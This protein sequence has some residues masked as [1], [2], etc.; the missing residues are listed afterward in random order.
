VPISIDT[1]KASTARLALVAGAKIIN[2]VWGLQR[3][4]DIARVAAEAGAPVIAMHN[5][6]FLDGSLDVLDDMRAYF[7]RSLAIAQ[8][9]GIPKE[10]VVL[11]PGIGFGKTFDQNLDALR[12]LAELRAL[13]QPILVGAS[14]KSML[15]RI[16]GGDTSPR[17]RL[18]ASVASHVV[19]AMLG[20]DIVRVHDV[21][22]HV[23]ALRVADAVLRGPQ[24]LGAS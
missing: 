6:D 22:A 15:G 24:A 9:A 5:R 16:L 11:D 20:A 4:P 3:D 23:E 10:F 21:R 2:D 13:G 12:R 8:A 14:R 7:A 18:F 17:E 1:Y 19:S